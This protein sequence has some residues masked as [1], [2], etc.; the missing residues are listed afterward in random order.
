MKK[1]TKG[2]IVFFFFLIL[3]FIAV[4][5][6]GNTYNWVRKAAC[7]I[8]GCTMEGDINMSGHSIINALWINTTYTNVTIN[9]TQLSDEHWVNETRE[10]GDF[11]LDGIL[12][13][14]S[15]KGDG[16]LL[17]GIPSHWNA[18]D[19]LTPANAT[20]SLNLT[21]N[22][23]VNTDFGIYSNTPYYVIGEP[24]P[25]IIRDTGVYANYQLYATRRHSPSQRIGFYYGA[26][27]PTF[28]NDAGSL[29]VEFDWLLGQTSHYI[30]LRLGSAGRRAGEFTIRDG[31]VAGAPYNLYI[32]P[33]LAKFDLF[34]DTNTNGNAEMNL[35]FDNKDTIN[36]KGNVSFHN[37]FTM[38]SPDG[39]NWNCGINNSGN[40]N[41]N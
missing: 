4:A 36:L 11:E 27:A 39:T 12:T 3:S 31:A 41:C 7:A 21:Q 9:Y 34:N 29:G 28:V 2:L 5:G 30:D 20:L 24:P 16:S 13:A 14:T 10:E 37:N 38:I 6:Q 33:L 25:L 17:T 40:I 26:S 22:I 15:F 35:G 23:T 18:T 19:V 1:L 8:T 32:S